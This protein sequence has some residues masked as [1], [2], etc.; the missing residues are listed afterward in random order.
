M[1]WLIGNKGM[2]GTD[3]EAFLEE[4]K[5]SSITSDKEVDITSIDAL[6]TFIGDQS[7]DYIINCA[8]YTAVDKAEDEEELAY[9]INSEGPKNIAII[10]KEKDAKLIHFSTDY[11]FSGNK[12]THTMRKT[13]Q[14]PSA[15]MERVNS[16]V[17]IIFLPPWK[18]IL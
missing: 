2:L 12:K 10:A 14:T 3:I 11:V 5:I 16:Q 1:V 13:K 8:A 4:K 15:S 18:N 9:R 7:I 17:K 6:R